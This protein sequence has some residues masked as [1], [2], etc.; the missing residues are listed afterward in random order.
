V[1]PRIWRSLTPALRVGIVIFGAILGLALIALIIKWAPQWLATKHLTATDEAEEVGRV[2]TALL[3]TLAGVLAAIGAYYTHRTFQLNRAALEHNRATAERS[4]ALDQARLI[5][6]RF[7][8]AV[9]QLGSDKLDVRLGGIYALERIARDSRDDHPQVMEVLTAY[10][11]EH[12]PWRPQRTANED[13]HT[14][15]API[16]AIRDQSPQ[17]KPSRLTQSRD[18]HGPDGNARDHEDE[19]DTELSPPPTD[20]QAAV[21]VLGRRDA[22][23]DR[24][25]V[26][27]DLGHTNLRRVTLSGSNLAGASLRGTNLDAAA[28]RRTNLQDADLARANLQDADLADADLKNANLRGANLRRARLKADL[29]GAVLTDANLR[30]ACL[31]DGDLSDAILGGADLE[32]ALLNGTN[33]NGADLAGA[34][35]K[36]ANLRGANLQGTDLAWANLRGADLSE[37]NLR[38]ANLDH[39]YLPPAL[40]PHSKSP[41]DTR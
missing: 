30:G 6:E 23:H 25:G 34:N 18:H 31:T 14:L 27:L 10:V 35:L 22:S 24:H 19:G 32:D 8:R 16:K 9:D 7:T 39:A 12:V 28:L 5:T 26:P 21:T 38:N 4:H 2:R 29:R 13:A 37:A 20:V 15:A 40:L 3:A 17:P 11:R 1:V 36:R 33:L 41:G